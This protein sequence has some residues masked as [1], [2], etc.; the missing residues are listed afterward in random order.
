MPY[1]RWPT[2]QRWEE[3][4][5]CGF[6]WPLVQ[7]RKDSFGSK[8]CPKCW[9]KDGFEEFRRQTA[10][11]YEDQTDMEKLNEGDEA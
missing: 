9:D 10:L 7:L 8:R 3:C 1:P 4:H 11:A 6:D 2:G 5:I